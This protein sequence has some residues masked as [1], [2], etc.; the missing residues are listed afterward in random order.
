VAKQIVVRPNGPDP[1]RTVE[2]HGEIEAPPAPTDA[3]TDSEDYLGEWVVSGF[4]VT[5]EFEGTLVSTDTVPGEWVI[6][7]EAGHVSA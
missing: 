7:T 2:F 3:P 1:A 5:V 4:T 6:E